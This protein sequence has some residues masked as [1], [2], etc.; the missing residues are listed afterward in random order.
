ML[1]GC[2]AGAAIGAAFG[3][4]LTGAFYAFELII[5][6]YTIA[7]A[8]AVLAASL[9]G[10]LTARAVRAVTYEIHMPPTGALSLADYPSM[11]VLG[12]VCAVLGVVMMR[13]VNLTE[14]AFDAV[15]APRPIR[16]AIGGCVM[17]GLA[18]I[19]P[20]VLAAGHGALSVDIPARLTIA[21]L[22]G[23]LGLKMF[24]S[25]VTL[26]SGFRGGLFFASL[27]LGALT[28]KLFAALA[29]AYA[30]GLAVDPDALH[31]GR[32]GRVRGGGDRRAAHHVVPGAGDHGRLRR[33]HHRAGLGDRDQHRGAGDLRLL[34]LHLAA[35]SARRDHPQRHRRGLDARAH[36][37][38]DDAA[39]AG[40]H[41]WRR[42]PG[43]V[44]RPLPAGLDPARG[45]RRR[46]T[47]ATRASC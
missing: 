8:G 46:T 12:L 35:A 29:A 45:R 21:A 14:R 2:G 4:P 43:R 1:V 22:L 32:H 38:S 30:P 37:R 16:P 28:G 47:A 20:Q 40:D 23:L 18:I 27:F 3:A 5:G 41:P 34:L 11:L 10:V 39:R 15:K 17:T 42:Q 31:P 33:H 44:P 19:T 6:T 26:G 9:A 24:A 13:A 36:R 25:M 7:T